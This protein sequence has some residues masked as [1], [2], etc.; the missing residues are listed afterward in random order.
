MRLRRKLKKL[1]KRAE[2]IKKMDRYSNFKR[3]IK[4]GKK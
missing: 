3:C 4:N 2:F 1:K